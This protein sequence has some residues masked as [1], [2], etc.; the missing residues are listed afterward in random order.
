MRENINITL[1]LTLCILIIGK[2]CINNY[3]LNNVHTRLQYLL[4]YILELYIFYWLGALV[5]RVLGP[6]FVIIKR[7]GFSESNL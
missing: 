2:P 1:T 7:L 3:I 5:D 4:Y 6:S